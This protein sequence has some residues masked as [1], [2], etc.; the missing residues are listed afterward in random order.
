LKKDHVS[1]SAGQISKVIAL[2]W[3]KR[4]KQSKMVLGKQRKSVQKVKKIVSGRVFFRFSKKLPA[5]EAKVQWNQL[6]K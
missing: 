1:W 3:V 6:P 5:E 4:K 2:M